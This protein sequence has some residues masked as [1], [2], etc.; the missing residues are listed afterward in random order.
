M[1]HLN[2]PNDHGFVILTQYPTHTLINLK[3]KNLP[4]GLH[5]FH[6]HEFGDLQNDCDSLGPCYNPSGG[7]H[8]DLNQ[9][10]SHA[11]DLGNIKVDSEGNCTDL[12]KSRHLRLDQ[13]IGRSMVIHTKP[14]DL[15]LGLDSES[16]KTDNSGERIA[17]G[18]ISIM[19][20]K[21]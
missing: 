15:G 18:I 9:T 12:I 3:L 10:S 14:D 7:A 11:G 19:D 4:E 17:C 21:N 2:Y 16:K 5:G 20:Q 13:I 6:I 1:C 8:G